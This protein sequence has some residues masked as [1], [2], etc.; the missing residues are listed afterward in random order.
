MT[1]MLYKQPG[2]AKTLP[3][4]A[5]YSLTSTALDDI[6]GEIEKQRKTP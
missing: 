3:S 1:G 5:G 6:V 4:G 2:S